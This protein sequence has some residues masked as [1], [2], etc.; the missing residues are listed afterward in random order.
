[1]GA[2][3]L[4]EGVETEDERAAL[5]GLGIALAQGWLFGKPVPADQW[6]QFA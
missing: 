3:V 2:Q 6:R 5:S 1:M 4:A